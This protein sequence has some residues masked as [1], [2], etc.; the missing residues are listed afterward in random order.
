VTPTGT[1][2]QRISSRPREIEPGVFVGRVVPTA[3]RRQIGPFVFL[4]HMGPR[5]LKPG[6]GMD[7]R[8][9]PHI[10]LATVTYLF[11]G[12]G[13]HRD[14]LGSHQ[15]IRPGDVNWM[16]AG[17]GIVHSERT[18]AEA[19]A[20]GGPM[21]GV[22]LWVGLP[23][24]HEA[25]APSFRH[26]P[27]HSLPCVEQQ[28][29]SFRVLAGSAFGARSPVETLWPLSFVD[30]QLAPGSRVL[31]P[32][33]QP[34]RAAYVVQGQVVCDGEPAGQGTLLV[35]TPEREAG[36]S[37]PNGARVIL[38]GGAPLDGPRYIWWNFV[39]SNQEAIVEAARAWR[40]GRFPKV[41]GDETDFVPLVGEP[42]FA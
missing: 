4:D 33:D 13:E 31:L 38:L 18:P 42:H 37:A 9:H 12:V 3:E 16:T 15:L 34:E 24:A 5:A 21:H 23:K 19:R 22:Q 32:A 6:Q 26:W 20:A 10:G 8:P 28:G 17:R 7:V 41:P 30:A 25:G 2:S 11:E 40:A 14:S 27:A 36:L 35:L 39:S 29:A 1:V